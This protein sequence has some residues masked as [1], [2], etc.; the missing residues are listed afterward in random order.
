MP[1]VAYLVLI[2]II[3][4]RVAIDLVRCQEIACY[5][6]AG[7]WTIIQCLISGARLL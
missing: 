6:I 7:L 3:R 1:C 5:S 4:Q 2:D